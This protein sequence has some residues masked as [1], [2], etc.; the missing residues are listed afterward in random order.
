MRDGRN[1][2][3]VYIDEAPRLIIED[4]L[5]AAILRKVVHHCG[6]KSA[7]GITIGDAIK[8][9]LLRSFVREARDAVA[10]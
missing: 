10:A 7:P 6:G 1:I 4:T 8:P 9:D 3:A 5:E 2:E